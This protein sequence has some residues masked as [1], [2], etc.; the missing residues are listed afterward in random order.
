MPF[1]GPFSTMCAVIV[2]PPPCS[3]V[4]RASSLVAVTNFVI[5]TRLNFSSPAHDRTICRTRTT[6]SDVRTGN[7][8]DF[9]AIG[10]FFQLAIFADVLCQQ[11]H[12][13]LDVQR[14]FY[15]RQRHAKLHQCDGHCRLHTRQY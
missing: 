4:L 9:T 5:S 11:L 15:A 7:V 2:P 1:F 14:G 6:S 13:A 10:I 3:S 12:P 8:S